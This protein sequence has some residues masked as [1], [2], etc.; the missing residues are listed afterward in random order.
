MQPRAT[1]LVSPAATNPSHYTENTVERRILHKYLDC[2]QQEFIMANL[3]APLMKHLI[4]ICKR[5]HKNRA[6]IQRTNLK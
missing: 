1:T 3:M 5:K 4:S 2:K 6:N